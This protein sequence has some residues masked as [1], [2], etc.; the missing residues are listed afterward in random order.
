[1]KCLRS[2]DTSNPKAASSCLPLGYASLAL[3]VSDETLNKSPWQD[4]SIT[5]ALPKVQGLSRKEDVAPI[6]K[7]NSLPRGESNGVEILTLL[8]LPSLSSQM[9][10]VSSHSITGLPPA[11][12]FLL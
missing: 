9:A 10:L 12:L 2:P 1:M 5:E 3:H 8:T 6:R 11:L 7:A 4:H